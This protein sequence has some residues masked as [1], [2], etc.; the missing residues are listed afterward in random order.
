MKIQLAHS[1]EEMISVENI[2]AAWQEFQKGKRARI[3]VGEFELSLMDNIFEL[4][5]DLVN[6]TYKHAGYQ[7]FNICD[8]KSRNIHKATV[9]DRLV[10]RGVYRILYPFFDRIFISDAFSCRENKG[11][12]RALNRFRKLGYIVSKN[13]TRTCWVLKCDIKKFFASI[14]HKIL[15]DILKICIPDPDIMWLLEEIIE[16]FSSTRAGVGL[17]LGNLTS[18]LF[19]NVYMNEFDQ[20]VKHKLKAKFYIRYADD[21]II[22]SHRKMWLEKA[23]NPIKEFLKNKLE[24]DLHPDKI[25]LKT[26]NSGMDFLG[27]AN[28]FTH[29]VLRTSTKRR[30]LKNLAISQNPAAL[31]SYLGLLKHGNAYKLSSIIKFGL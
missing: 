26:L 23:L 27:W 1:F 19:A 31:N 25:F 29:R 2:L 14:D 17:P 8:P 21:F 15:L 13:N 9:R 6:H 16:S 20:F 3:D 11:T 24:L 5:H 30:M 22:L 18:Q 12:H 28:F 7:A 4:H 10:H